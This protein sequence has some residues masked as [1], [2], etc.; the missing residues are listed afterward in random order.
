MLGAAVIW[1]FPFPDA[2]SASIDTGRIL[3]AELREK[4]LPPLAEI[5]PVSGQDPP[6]RVAPGDLAEELQAASV[7]PTDS[8]RVAGVVLDEAY[9]LPV[10]GA[11]ITLR[12]PAFEDAPRGS[13]VK[14]I[15]G[16]GGV[17]EF[18]LPAGTWR[19]GRTC[20]VLIT[21]GQRE[22]LFLGTAR[23]EPEM[24]LY[25]RTTIDLRGRLVTNRDPLEGVSLA[26]HVSPTGAI[27]IPIYAG[28][29][30]LEKD[31]SFTILA[32]AD[33][34]PER[35][36]LTFF[37][38]K[39]PLAAVEV[40]T[41]ELRSPTGA[42]VRVTLGELE[43]ELV[44]QEGAPVEGADLRLARVDGKAP[45][46]VGAQVTDAAGRV[47]L[48][49]TDGVYEICAGKSG[50]SPEVEIVTTAVGGGK[51]V[52]RI[53]LHALDA[54]DHVAGIVLDTAG[55]PVPD[56]AVTAGP[57]THHHDVSVA[58][59]ERA[60]TNEQG[61]FR[62]FRDPH[63]EMTLVANHR[64]L[65]A[66]PKIEVTPG[67][68]DVVLR[69]RDQGRV[70]VFART[71]GLVEPNRS[72]PLQ[73]VLVDRVHEVTASAHSWSNPIEFDALP[74]GDYNLYIFLDGRGGYAQTSFQVLPGD[75][76]DVEVIL[77]NAVFMSGEVHT[78]G[79]E[80]APRASVQVIGI[81]DWPPE[82]AELLGRTST[83]EHGK[84]K[85]LTGVAT[86]ATVRVEGETGAWAEARLEAAKPATVLIPDERD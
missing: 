14:A 81:P 44:D 18:D 25:A 75:N 9:G 26:A 5:E 82:V 30:T 29:T 78:S 59:I 86:E 36:L 51:L 80:V 16:E 64:K 54:D 71:D 76:E 12:P 83:D 7:P 69:Y 52:R 73:Y 15:T 41:A 43:L 20:D 66:T 79:G 11:T 32:R 1:W 70:R 48:L 50:Y 34:I 67:G 46:S 47:R 33:R 65:G 53:E 13:S 61:R 28:S 62:L 55:E 35:F 22:R 42:D 24:L 49:V 85:V 21:D 19:E 84:F 4:P 10:V 72:G 45:G 60:Y 17:F 63:E 2:R 40:P 6:S 68:R 39:S 56:A 77:H 57:L 58:G 37:A 23:L 8:F 38:D 3:R 31:A 74:V 27:T